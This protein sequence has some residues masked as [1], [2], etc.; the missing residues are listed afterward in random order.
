MTPILQPFDLLE[1]EPY[2]ERDVRVGDVVAFQLEGTARHVVHRVARVGTESIHTIGDN[3]VVE[4]IADLKPEDLTGRVVVA[5]RGQKYRKVHGG[6]VGNLIG[7]IVRLAR[8]FDRAISRILRPIYHALARQSILRVV[9]PRS[10]RPRVVRF[11]NPEHPSMMLIFLGRAIGRY[12]IDLGQWIIRRP[13][14]LF[15]DEESLP[16]QQTADSQQLT[17]NS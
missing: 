15:V 8:R 9:L 12:D 13:F 17:A 16:S 6:A 11:G 5:W 14:K 3:N 2:R 1:I 4:D 7:R 10:L